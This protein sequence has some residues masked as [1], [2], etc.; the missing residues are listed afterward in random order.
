MDW[1]PHHVDKNTTN[2][3]RVCDV[4]DLHVAV[5]SSGSEDLVYQV[6]IPSERAFP[7]LNHSEMRVSTSCLCQLKLSIDR[8][9][10]GLLCSTIFSLLV[11]ANP[12]NTL[13]APRSLTCRARITHS[14]FHDQGDVF[15]G[16]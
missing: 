14:E 15:T 5:L 9:A 3:F 2:A 6:R 4:K 16:I 11:L 1:Q 10:L 8:S 7:A 13:T 12:Q